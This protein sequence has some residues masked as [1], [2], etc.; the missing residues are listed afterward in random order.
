M[1]GPIYLN[2]AYARSTRAQVLR[3]T[4]GEGGYHVVLSRSLLYPEGGGQPPDRGW[5]NGQ[6]VRELIPGDDGSLSHVIDAP[7]QGEGEVRLDWER[8]FDHMQQHTAQHMI[9]AVASDLFG[10]CTTA[11]HLGKER[12]D[13]E[14][15]TPGL[16][17]D[18]KEGIE[19]KVNALIAE[20]RPVASRFVDASALESE[21]IR[22]RGLPKDFTGPVRLVEIQGVDT[23]TCGGTH[24]ANTAEL[25][26]IK[27]L[28]I[29]SLRNGT[30]LFY[31]AGHRMI[32][33]MESM[34][35]RERALTRALSC[36]PEGHAQSLG[37]I[38]EE[39]KS[40][41]QQER[42]LKKELAVLIGRS[43]GQQGRYAVY[44]HPDGDMEFLRAIVG[45]AR[46]GNRDAVFL[47]F[48]GDSSGIFLLAGPDADVESMG[49]L[50]A[51]DAGL[52]GG[53]KGGLFQGKFENVDQREAAVRL[54]Q[55][56]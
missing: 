55:G 4:Q 21:K 52:R 47:V 29:E 1:T 3:C 50:L 44:H 10:I 49:S 11:F 32:R 41:K 39:L 26:A 25:Q 33:L 17:A 45:S 2:D 36:S 56:Q 9:T 5:I 22:S 13:I 53:G 14:L 34:L 7:V 23:N 46:Q 40:A 54:V 6:E 51:C 35:V 20:G 16:P 38:Q 48:A 18:Q 12:S 30:R 27:L 42:G 24:V 28:H 15:D 19:R 8:R 31:V 43:L 37:R